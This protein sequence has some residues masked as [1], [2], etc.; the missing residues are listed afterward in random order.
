M[1]IKLDRTRRFKI[2]LPAAAPTL[3]AFVLRA[4]NN[5]AA[6]G[7]DSCAHGSTSDAFSNQASS[8]S[9]AQGTYGRSGPRAGSACARDQRGAYHQTEE[10]ECFHDP[11]C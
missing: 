1:L 3:V 6:E 10:C 8:G 4:P 11:N 2:D 9:S 7:S 5:I